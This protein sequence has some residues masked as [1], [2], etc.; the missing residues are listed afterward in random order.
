MVR[1]ISLST[2]LQRY[3]KRDILEAQGRKVVIKGVTGSEEEEKLLSR[4]H[5]AT[6]AAGSY[7]NHNG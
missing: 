3:L 1:F 7:S 5:R 4:Q 6:A 2:P